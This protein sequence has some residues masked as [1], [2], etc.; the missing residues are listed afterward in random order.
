MGKVS[1]WP[2]LA[3]A[4]GAGG[5]KLEIGCPYSSKQQVGPCDPSRRQNPRSEAITKV[6]GVKFF[7]RSRMSARTK[8]DWSRAERQ[9]D[10][11]WS[12]AVTTSQSAPSFAKAMRSTAPPPTGNGARHL[13]SGLPEIEK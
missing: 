13:P 6:V 10:R 11:E 3:R 9:R 2:C 8:S 4:M 5:G 12:G 1:S 7:A